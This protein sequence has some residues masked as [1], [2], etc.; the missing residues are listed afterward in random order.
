MKCSTEDKDEIEYLICQSVKSVKDW[1]AHLLR[2]INQDEPKHDISNQ[3]DE[4]T[5][6]LASDWAMKYLPRKYRESQRD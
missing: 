3:I 1:K 6:L 5:L 2:S 4:N